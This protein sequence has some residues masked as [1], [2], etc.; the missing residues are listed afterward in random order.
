MDFGGSGPGRKQSFARCG[1]PAAQGVLCA[2][3]FAADATF[4]PRDRRKPRQ[5]R[6]VRACDYA[7]RR[8]SFGG[9]IRA[10]C[11]LCA[12]AIALPRGLHTTRPISCRLARSVLSED[13]NVPARLN[14]GQLLRLGVRAPACG[15]TL[16]RGNR[17]PR[18]TFSS[19]GDYSNFP[20]EN[21]RGRDLSASCLQPPTQMPP[22]T[23]RGRGI[24]GEKQRP[25]SWLNDITAAAQGRG[26]TSVFGR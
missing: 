8:S 2:I 4:F 10:D 13:I 3:A 7:V 11:A 24:P 25:V 19:R 5:F 17:K 21:L 23:Y 16:Q 14:P 9:R 1:G 20:N 12:I 18:S 15:R 6:I 26:C 22:W